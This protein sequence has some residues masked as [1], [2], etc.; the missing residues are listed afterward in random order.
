MPTTLG[1]RV[2]RRRRAA[3]IT[4]KALA[5][6]TRMSPAFIS[7]LESGAR[8]NI[9]AHLLARVAKAL[10]ATVEELLG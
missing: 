2:R 7:R 9:S 1:S 5:A 8:R 3:G 6:R 4:Q 10:G